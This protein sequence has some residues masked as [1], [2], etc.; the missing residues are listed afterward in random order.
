MVLGQ[1]RDEA[2]GGAGWRNAVSL[3]CLQKRWERAGE[4][5]W[6]LPSARLGHASPPARGH[7]AAGPG[8]GGLRAGLRAPCTCGLQM[9]GGGDFS[10]STAGGQFV[11][12][13]P[14]PHLP[15]P[16]L[17]EPSLTHGDHRCRHSTRWLQT[18]GSAR[19]SPATGSEGQG[20]TGRVGR[21]GGA[22]PRARGEA[23]GRPQA[24]SAHTASHILCSRRRNFSGWSRGRR[25]GR[26]TWGRW[27]HR[28]AE[29]CSSDPGGGQWV[30][31]RRPT[32]DL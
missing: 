4:G 18:R 20:H 11:R 17:S 14:P 3:W 15:A 28:R 32:P 24:C 10:A 22:G 2:G 21:R 6:S 19:S 5:R 26:G 23:G 29:A 16:L 7:P 25:S 13:A 31:G 1:P 12:T 9:A 30:A 27:A 8:P